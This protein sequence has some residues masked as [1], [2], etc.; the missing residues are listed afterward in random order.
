MPGNAPIH[1][2]PTQL[3][4]V[5]ADACYRVANP[6]MEPVFRG[7]TWL[8]DEKLMVAGAGTV[9]LAL[10]AL[11]RDRALIR[12]ADQMICSVAI[13]AAA[14]HVLKLAFVRE[15]PDRI[16]AGR[17]RK[18]IPKSGKGWDSF[19]SGHAV[20]VGALAVAASRM[21]PNRLALIWSSALGLAGT[22]VIL[23]A[24]YLT[25]VVAGFLAG[26]AIDQTVAGVFRLAGLG[27]PAPRVAT[28]NRR[29]RPDKQLSGNVEAQRVL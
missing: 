7:L 3:D 16:R 17:R 12:A 15:R 5:V 6:K 26:I 2:P 22:R 9:W 29:L 21:A 1:V 25:D 4:R 19:P 23:L 18:G 28:G 20:H 10:R 8:A 24:H 27:A 11:S 14:P 13:A